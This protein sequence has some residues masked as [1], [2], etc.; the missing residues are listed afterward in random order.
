M[1][2]ILSE[3]RLKSLGMLIDDHLDLPIVDEDATVAAEKL[4]KHITGQNFLRFGK[5]LH[6]QAIHISENGKGYCDSNIVIVHEVH[7][8]VALFKKERLCKNCLKKFIDR[9]GSG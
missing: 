3:E 5:P 9:F 6:S 1:S 7:H 2:V 8:K 4:I